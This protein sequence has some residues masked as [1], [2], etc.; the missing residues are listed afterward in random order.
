MKRPATITP[1]RRAAQDEKLDKDFPLLTLHTRLRI[2]GTLKQ[3]DRG[4]LLI[5]KAHV[6]WIIETETD[7]TGLLG[8]VILVDG[9]KT[10]MDRIS[11]DYVGRL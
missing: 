9:T 5:T 7:L 8:S 4:P 3:S 11:A 2:S 1:R 10:A 6:A